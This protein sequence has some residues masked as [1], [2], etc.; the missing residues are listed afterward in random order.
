[1]ANRWSVR[2]TELLQKVREALRDEIS[3]A[4]QFSEVIGDRGIMK[5]IRGHQE[6][7]KIVLMYGNYL[8]WRKS[9]GADVIRERIRLE[10]L[11][12]PELFPNGEGFL[13]VSP[14][15]IIAADATD[16]VGNLITFETFDYSPST[17][18]AKYSI[19]QWNEWISYTMQYKQMV[20]EQVSEQRERALL[21]EHGG[22]PPCTPEKGY[23][24][25]LQCTGIRC[26]KGIGMEYLG[27]DA[28]AI[29][30]SSVAICQDNFPEMLYKTHM[31]QAP[32]VFNTLWYFLKGFVDPRTISKVNMHGY[33][34]LPEVIKD[35]PLES[36]PKHFGG[37]YTGY[38]DAFNFDW[39]E[40][41]LMDLYPEL[42]VQSSEKEIKVS[43]EE[44][45]SGTSEKE[46][47]EEVQTTETENNSSDN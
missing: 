31:V 21:A 3:E 12:R 19:D 41:G 18:L 36:V 46:G 44:K 33:N 29:I 24:I 40:G 42:K 5:F 16:N 7:D 30:K 39:S 25:I 45:T 28:K 1:M 34:F 11:N 27:S 47:T 37:K 10:N 35:I 14:Q 2:E 22:N 32:W 6:F 9:S 13:S 8:K 43:E 4:G 23:G 15:I 17:L 38:N 26:L 20:L